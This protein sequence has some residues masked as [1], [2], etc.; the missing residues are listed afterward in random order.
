MKN[1]WII[2]KVVWIKYYLWPNLCSQRHHDTWKVNTEWAGKSKQLYSWNTD[3]FIF[4][5]TLMRFQF[6]YDD[7]D[8]DDEDDYAIYGCSLC[9]TTPGVLQYRSNTRGR[10]LLQLLLV[11]GWYMA[12]W[13]VKSKIKYCILTDYSL[14][15]PILFLQ[16][17]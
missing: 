9:R 4:Y 3:V 14:F 15:S 6:I 13:N 8:D 11:V 10:R 12:I 1:G 2:G 16:Y 7:D 17:A 5:L